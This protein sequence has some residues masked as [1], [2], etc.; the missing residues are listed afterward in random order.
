MAEK[1]TED[2]AK[3]EVRVGKYTKTE[4]EA[5]VKKL[6]EQGYSASIVGVTETAPVETEWKPAIGDVVRFIGSKQYISS[7][8]DTVRG[9]VAGRATI[10]AYA[11]GTKHPYHL[12]RTGDTGPYGWVDTGTFTKA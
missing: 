1:P 9:A 12:V 11:E 8:S 2:S 3:Y 4:A 5:V 10:T 6:T 7:D